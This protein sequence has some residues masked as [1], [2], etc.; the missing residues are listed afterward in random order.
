MCPVTT[1]RN[2]VAGREFAPIT[3][4]AEHPIIEPSAAWLAG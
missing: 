1:L 4:Q 3:A 2:P